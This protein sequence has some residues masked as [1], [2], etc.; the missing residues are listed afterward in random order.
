M[1]IFVREVGC[2][3]KHASQLAII[4]KS[5]FSFYYRII[6]YFP[7]LKSLLNKDNGISRLMAGSGFTG[8]LNPSLIN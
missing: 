8:L 1:Y 7:D 5:K 4:R 2:K 3:K 6:S